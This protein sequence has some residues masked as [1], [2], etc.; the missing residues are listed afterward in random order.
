M[1]NEKI[2]INRAEVS[3]SFWEYLC[4]KCKA[5]PFKA[6]EVLL[7]ATDCYVEEYQHDMKDDDFCGFGERSEK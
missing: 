5:D 3:W 7:T 4:F 6:K 2:A 1:A